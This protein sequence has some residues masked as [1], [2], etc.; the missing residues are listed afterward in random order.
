MTTETKAIDAELLRWLTLPEKKLAL[1]FTAHGWAIVEACAMVGD[2]AKPQSL[3]VK[4]LG[5]IINNLVEEEAPMAKELEV[6]WLVPAD[7][8][9]ATVAFETDALKMVSAVCDMELGELQS[10]IQGGLELS[11][12]EFYAK[13]GHKQRLH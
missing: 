1:Q 2:Y 4:I 10:S 12:L 6:H 9:T 5:N 11:L 3:V 8:L 7:R 13:H